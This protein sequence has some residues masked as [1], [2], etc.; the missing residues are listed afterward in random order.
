MDKDLVIIGPGVDAVALD[1]G[2]NTQILSISA[3]V[4]VEISDLTFQ[5]GRGAIN[6]AGNLTIARAAFV[7]NP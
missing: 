1:G 5:N 6:N 4:T 2:N 7:N 3:G